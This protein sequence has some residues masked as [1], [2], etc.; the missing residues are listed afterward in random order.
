MRESVVLPESYH[1]LL[2]DEGLQEGLL[3]EIDIGNYEG[4]DK[5][6]IRE[7]VVIRAKPF[8][9]QRQD[10][11]QTMLLYDNLII[12]E[13]DPTVDYSGLME[14]GI[15]TTPIEEYLAYNPLKEE[16]HK[17][18]AEYLRGAVV[19]VIAKSI[20]KRFKEIDSNADILALAF[21]LYDTVLGLGK[22]KKEEEVLVD[23][24][25]ETRYRKNTLGFSREIVTRSFIHEILE[26]YLELCW[27]LDLS[28][29]EEADLLDTGY[30]LTKLGM[31]SHGENNKIKAYGVLKCAYEEL[32]HSLPGFT[33]LREVMNFKKNRKSEIKDLK[34]EIANLE[35]I[36][37]SNN[38]SSERKA[39]EEAIGDISKARDA[40]NKGLPQV[41]KIGRFMTLMGAP[42]EAIEYYSD[43]LKGIPLGVAVSGIGGIMC[44]TEKHLERKSKW[45][46]IIR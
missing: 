44:F 35:C 13:E 46:E 21:S 10:F 12:P 4:L 45:I 9:V 11:Y 25:L 28:T 32:I 5:N 33:D 26:K 39:F 3:K 43:Y 2:I 20:E 41:N 24:Y 36:L 34:H 7:S 6:L 38:P 1:A 23:H 18:S 27:R 31:C 17:E 37:R 40:L 8:L 22:L 19:P 30:D 29:Q 16:G 15:I 14:N 42:I